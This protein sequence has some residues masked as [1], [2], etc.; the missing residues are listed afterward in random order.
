MVVN[1]SSGGSGG[2]NRMEKV[3]LVEKVVVVKKVVVCCGN[4]EGFEHKGG[5][6]R[7]TA[8]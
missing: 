3:K 6:F 4:H 1:P 2:E 5:P 8:G 7:S